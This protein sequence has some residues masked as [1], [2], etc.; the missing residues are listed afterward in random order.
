MIVAVVTALN[1]LLGEEGEFVGQTF[2]ELQVTNPRLADMVW[3]LSV[4]VSSLAF[5]ASLLVVLLAWRGLSSGSR[6]VWYSIL[7]LSITFPVGVVA[8]H[9]PIYVRHWS[10]FDHW[11]LPFGLALVQL[12]GLAI[13]AKPVFSGQQEK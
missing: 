2:R 4:G 8:S 9:V 10:S 6:L 3:H 5:G 13:T 7:I 1:P 11:F 12:V